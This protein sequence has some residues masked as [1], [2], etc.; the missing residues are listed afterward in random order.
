MTIDPLKN[1]MRRS[2]LGYLRFL[3]FTRGNNTKTGFA[4]GPL[5]RIIFFR[6]SLAFGLTLFCLSLFSH[7]IAPL[8][9]FQAEAYQFSALTLK[10]TSRLHRKM[11]AYGPKRTFLVAPHMSAFGGKADITRT[12]RHTQR[13]AGFHQKHG[14][15]SRMACITPICALALHFSMCSF[16]HSRKA[17][18]IASFDTNDFG[19]AKE[20]DIVIKSEGSLMFFQCQSVRKDLTC[21][22]RHKFQTKN[23]IKT[24]LSSS[25]LF[26]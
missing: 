11:S 6:R 16:A 9:S 18:T 10:L 22:G 21:H 14:Q 17:S 13:N 23:F 20:T 25:A 3:F 12:H 7:V 19:H 4:G 24:S 1:I 8:I 5:F 26:V 2:G 15:V